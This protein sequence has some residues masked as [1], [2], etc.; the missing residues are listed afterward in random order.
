MQDNNEPLATKG[1]R[2]VYTM[3]SNDEPLVTKSNRAKT[4]ND[5]EGAKF[6]S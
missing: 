5:H 2:A 1:F 3:Q 4:F 6:P